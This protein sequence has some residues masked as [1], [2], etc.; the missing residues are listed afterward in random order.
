[1]DDDRAMLVARRTACRYRDLGVYRRGSLLLGFL[2]LGQGLAACDDC[3]PHEWQALVKRKDVLACT[4]DSQCILVGQTSTCDCSESMA[5]DGV[6]VNGDAYRAAGGE[7]MLESFYRNCSGHMPVQC[8]DCA[9]RSGTGC[10]NGECAITRYYGCGP[11]LDG[12]MYRP[13]AD[14][15]PSAVVDA[16]VDAPESIYDSN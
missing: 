14:S 3:D 9:P 4:S 8:C 7:L 2:L 5:G 12:G 10:V 13:Q 15:A 16:D 1:M 6:A 11:G